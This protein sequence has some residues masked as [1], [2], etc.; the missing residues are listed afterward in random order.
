MANSIKDTKRLKEQI[1][2]FLDSD[3]GY[4]KTSKAILAVL[5]IGSV[6]FVGALAPNIFQVLRSFNIKRFDKFNEDSIRN[7][8]YSLQRNGFIRIIKEKNG[9]TK[10]LLTNKGKN[11]IKE[12]SIETLTIKKHEHWD[13]KWRVVIFDIPVKFNDGRSALRY[14][15]KELGFIYLQRSVWVFP[16][17]C[18]DEILF[19]A[20]TYNV[21]S[22]IDV[23]L[24]DSFLKEDKLKKIFNLT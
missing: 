21:D 2:D 17:P 16:Y 11:R 6:V 18:E 24:V 22:F 19:I 10:V 12:F 1:E 13:R 4:A 15:M 8:I 23:L 5:A 20:K 9:K 3:S 7:S 14:K